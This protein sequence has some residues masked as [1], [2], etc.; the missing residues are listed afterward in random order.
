MPEVL[1][2]A[3]VPEDMV[4]EFKGL[5]GLRISLL[6]SRLLNDKLSRLIRLEKI[7]SKSEL[8]EDKAKEIADDISLSLSE[9][10]DELYKQTYGK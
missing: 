3:N 5:S 2:K 4:D 10:Y 6:V 7:L 9:R 1:L 8:S